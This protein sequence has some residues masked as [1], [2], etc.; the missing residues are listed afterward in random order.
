MKVKITGDMD[1]IENLDE[2]IKLLGSKVSIEVD[3]GEVEAPTEEKKTITVRVGRIYCLDGLP[4]LLDDIIEDPQNY[5]ETMAFFVDDLGSVKMIP[6]N[7]L[8]YYGLEEITDEETIER[9]FSVLD[10]FT[11]GEE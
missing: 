3:L 10:E 11:N 6:T 1:D 2:I 5:E 4:V 9:F 7:K 8:G